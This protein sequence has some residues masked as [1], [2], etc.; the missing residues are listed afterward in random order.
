MLRERFPGLHDGWSRLDGPAGTQVVDT[1]IEAMADWMRSGHSA[2]H[3]GRFSAAH[4]T[5]RLVEATRAACARLLGADPRGVV[6]GPSMTAATFGFTSALPLGEGDQVVCTR[7]DHDANVAPW[8]HAARRAGAEVVFADPDPE[9]LTL[10][11]RNVEPLLSDRTR[12]VAVTGASNAC[13]TIPDLTGITEAAKAAG[14]RVFVDCV[15]LAPH[16]PISATAWGVD[17][18]ACSAY[19]WFGPHVGVLAADPALLEELRPDK[20]RPSPD[21]VPDRFERGTLPFESLAGVKAAAEFLL[22]EVDRDALRRHEDGLLA[23]MLDGLRGI[24]GVVVHGAAPDRTST[25][26]FTVRG[27]ASDEV[28]QRLADDHRVAVWGG[29]YYAYELFEHLGLNEE[30]AVR[31]GAVLYNDDRDVDRLL[32]GVAQIAS[33]S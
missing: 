28:A 13:G 2:N 21:E 17:A 6:F 33:A 18:V 9:A 27:H 5:D 10:G 31:A 22:D 26:M 12:W 25:V 29:N 11:A 3:G 1:A 23:R 4:E 24:D 7:L 8:L 14:A 15:H 20:L 16:R 19:K 30:G 32:E